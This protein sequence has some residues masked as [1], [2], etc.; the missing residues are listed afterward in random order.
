MLLM[1]SVFS[2]L[3]YI[4]GSVGYRKKNR[5]FF[6]Y[7]T[8]ERAGLEFADMNARQEL[9]PE[10]W[11]AH[12]AKRTVD[13]PE[14][15]SILPAG[16][17]LP[18][19]WPAILQDYD[20]MKSL[21]WNQLWLDYSEREGLDSN[22]PEQAYDARKIREQWVVFSICVPLSVLTLLVIIRT[23][24]RRIIADD[25]GITA[26]GAKTIP[27]DDIH[28]LDLRKWDNKGIAIADY[29]GTTGSGR[30]RI[31]G[32]TYGG[33]KKDCGEPAEKLMQRLRSRFSGELLEYAVINEPEELQSALQSPGSS[34]NEGK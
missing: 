24:R 20:K 15:K 29:S 1:F 22:P 25:H 16:L 8:F 30:L 7:Q 13:F 34:P 19:P 6:L 10:I 5:V 11:E 12:A 17:E 27:Y 18:M 31:D 32:L 2:V 28:R 9:T 14:D 23:S 33:F 3:F 4:D 21:Q 26:P